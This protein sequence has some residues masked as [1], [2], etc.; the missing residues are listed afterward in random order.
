MPY[1]QNGRQSYFRV[2]EF[3]FGTPRRQ[4]DSFPS[5]GMLPEP[6]LH[7]L[8]SENDDKGAIFMKIHLPYN[9]GV[10]L[11]E[12][13]FIDRYMPAA[14]GEFVKI[15]LYLL[16]CA[17]SGI[18]DL[19]ISGIADVFDHTEADVRRAL[20]Y[21]V[22]VKLIELNCDEDGSLKDVRLL[23]PAGIPDKAGSAAAGPE[24]AALLNDLLLPGK[25]PV[26]PA[27][28]A[29]GSSSAKMS[30][31][32]L[33]SVSAPSFMAREGDPPRSFRRAEYLEFFSRDPAAAPSV[34]SKSLPAPPSIPPSSSKEEGA[35][36]NEDSLPAD[37]FLFFF[38]GSD[39][40]VPSS[41]LS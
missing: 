12:N 20:N 24:G 7:K 6:D 18:S 22:K 5:E 34:L 41:C 8:I 30:P 35:S 40:P 1:W 38:P 26:L 11:I 27:A 19:S 13:T 17:S 39:K 3:P 14:N 4:G 10:T 23:H 36:R 21:W 29:S 25:D 16:R 32:T 9:G 33:W 28:S 31:R 15:Y 2:P 37:I